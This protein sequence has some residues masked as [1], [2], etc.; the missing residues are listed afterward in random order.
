[1]MTMP[2]VA[3]KQLALT[4]VFSG[5]IWLCCCLVTIFVDPAAVFTSTSFCWLSDLFTNLSSCLLDA[6]C[7]SNSDNFLDSETS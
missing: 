1:M 3:S 6:N 5:F 7:F 2:L 4:E